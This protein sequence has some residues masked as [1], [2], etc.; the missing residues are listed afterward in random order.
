MFWQSVHIGV[1]T[2][3]MSEIIETYILFISVIRAFEYTKKV[4]SDMLSD[5]FCRL[6]RFASRWRELSHCIPT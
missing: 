4:C 5:S 3:Y 1:L 6:H 2:V